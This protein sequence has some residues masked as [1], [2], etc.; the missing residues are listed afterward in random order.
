MSL[1][2]NYVIGAS[3]FFF[4]R[5]L[6]VYAPASEQHPVNRSL[7][8]LNDIERF[9]VEIL[10]DEE[11]ASKFRQYLSVEEKKGEEVFNAVAFSLF[12]VSFCVLV[13]RAYS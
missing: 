4:Q 13:I 9:V 3:N 5:H 2:S 12:Y 10:S 7:D 11:Y 6:Q 1:I 8:E